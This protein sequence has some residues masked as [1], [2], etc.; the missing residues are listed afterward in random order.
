MK[1]SP[2]FQAQ[3]PR[4][5]EACAYGGTVLCSSKVGGHAVLPLLSN[6]LSHVYLCFKGKSYRFLLTFS[7]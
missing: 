5:P 2:L 6:F 4:G 3:Y 7:S 1:M